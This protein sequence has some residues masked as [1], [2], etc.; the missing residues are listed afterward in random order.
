[1]TNERYIELLKVA[2]TFADGDF[3]RL[4]AFVPKPTE[5]ALAVRKAFW[6]APR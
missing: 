5:I 4:K 1:M 2:P 3:E 6:P